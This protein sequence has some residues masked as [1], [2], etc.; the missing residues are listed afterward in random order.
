[1]AILRPF[2][3]L[4]PEP[5]NAA[6]VSAVPYD[7]VN[8]EEAASLAKNNALSFLRVSRPEIDL[9]IEIHFSD[10]RVYEKAALQFQLLKKDAPLLQE[11]APCIYLYGLKQEA[12]EQIGIAA[13]YSVAE[14]D[15]GT[16]LRH[17]KTRPDKEDD[18]T[19][20][21]LSLQAQTGPVFLAFRETRTIDELIRQARKEMPLFNFIAEDGVT[22]TVWKIEETLPWI[23]AFAELPRLYIADGHHRSAS[24]SRAHRELGTTGNTEAH[25]H[26]LAVAFP[27]NQLRIL[28]Y[29]RLIKNWG[30]LTEV[31]FLEKVKEHFELLPTEEPSPPQGQFGMYLSGRWYR[32]KPIADIPKTG[33]ESLDVSVLQNRLLSP[34]LQ[35]QDPRSDS[36]IDFVG[37]IRGTGELEARVNRGEAVVAF[38]CHPTTLNE[39]MEIS[40]AGEMMPPKSTWFEPKLRDGLLSNT[41]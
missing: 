19:R 4:R 35:I 1:M 17:E 38:A 28:P 39:L 8:R 7:V 21:V 31:Q 22:H 23:N 27:A 33:V 13:T 36:R 25:G 10:A 12:H 20:H 34:I 37:G 26:F 5:K 2:R 29:N 40:D 24:A 30:T 9:P 18:R 41:F 14:Y 15:N 16:I 32:L 11:S 6:Q 3:A